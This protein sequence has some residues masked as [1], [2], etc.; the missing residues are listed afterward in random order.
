MHSSQNMHM[1]HVIVNNHN[2]VQN[3][4]MYPDQDPRNQPCQSQMYYKVNLKGQQK[5]AM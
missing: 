5:H 2:F 3:I 1:G 4:N